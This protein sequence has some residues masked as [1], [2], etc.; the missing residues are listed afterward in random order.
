MW[1]LLVQRNLVLNSFYII[2]HGIFFS[3]FDLGRSLKLGLRKASLLSNH[4]LSP[5]YA[6]CQYHPDCY[7]GHNS[8]TLTLPNRYDY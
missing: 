8:L 1:A 4:R 2:E 7:T 3:H 6:F 5:L